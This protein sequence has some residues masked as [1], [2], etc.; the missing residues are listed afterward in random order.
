MWMQKYIKTWWMPAQTKAEPRPW[1]TQST[2]WDPDASGMG[3]KNKSHDMS[4]LSRSGQ[5]IWRTPGTVLVSALLLW[6]DT[7]TRQSYKRNHLIRTS[8]QFHSFSPLSLWRGAWQH[9]GRH[10]PE[11]GAESSTSGSSSS[12]KRSTGPGLSNWK[13]KACPHCYTSSIKGTPIHHA[14]LW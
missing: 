4:C 13:Q 2:V 14:I 6:R 8:L 7:M 10:A 9:A 5:Q 3:H 1:Q 11:E 12:R